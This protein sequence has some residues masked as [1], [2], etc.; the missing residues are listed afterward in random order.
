M[1]IKGKDGNI[2]TEEDQIME[3]WRQHFEE[4]TK[5][6]NNIMEEQEELNEREEIEEIQEKEGREAIQKIKLGKAAGRDKVTPEMIK[7]MGKEGITKFTELLNE[8]MKTT[9]IPR[10]WNVG[11]ILPT[12]EG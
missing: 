5:S 8:I 1:Y 10:E 3:R 6:E 9:V 11:I 12:T 7:H 2:I 4:L